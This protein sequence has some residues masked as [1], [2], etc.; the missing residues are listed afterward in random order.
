MVELGCPGPRV[1]APIPEASSA[2]G[3]FLLFSETAAALLF[4]FFLACFFEKV[5]TPLRS[6]P[7]PLSPMEEKGV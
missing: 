3:D 7:S 5:T 1:D 6:L 4:S 2:S